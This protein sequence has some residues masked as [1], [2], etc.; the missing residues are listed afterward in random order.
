MEGPSSSQANELKQ[1]SSVE[2]IDL[3]DDYNDH[4]HLSTDLLIHR[5]SDDSEDNNLD[6]CGL[7]IRKNPSRRN[8]L[9]LVQMM[10]KV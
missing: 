5:A 1:N 6:D 10:M 9:I 3:D 8:R 7:E 2:I 4:L